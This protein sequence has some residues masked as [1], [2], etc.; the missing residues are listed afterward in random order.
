MVDGGDR[1]VAFHDSAQP[2][3]KLPAHES[4][5]PVITNSVDMGTI[6][7]ERL[8]L[9]PLRV[10]D[11]DEMAGVLDD[12]RL[13]EFTG[14]RPATVDELRAHY[15]RLVAGPARPDEAWLNWIVRRRADKQPVGTVQATLTSRAGGRR[16]NVAW[17]IGTRWQSQGFASEAARA[18]VE[19]LQDQGTQ[20]IVAY[21]HADNHASAAVATRAGLEP[22]DDQVDGEQVWRLPAG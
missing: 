22:T 14:G 21:V 2:N 8:S 7:T 1:A 9:V 20:E 4:R 5:M 11:A 6:T 17:V 18:L 13:H 15:E 10:K 19:W 16:A 12:E 3:G